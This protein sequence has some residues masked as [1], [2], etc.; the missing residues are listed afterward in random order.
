MVKLYYAPGA[1]SLSPHIVL[2]ETGTPFEMVK[3]DLAAKKAAD[4]SDFYAKNPGGYVPAL[5]TDDGT[6][7][8]EGPVIVTY[9]ADKSGKLAP[10]YGSPERYRM[11]SWLNFITSELHKGFSPLF[12]PRVQDESKAI[13]KDRLKMRLG[14]VDKHLASNDYLLGKSFT[15]PDA[16]LFTVLNWTK[17]PTVAIDLAKEFPN[18]AKFVDRVAERPS[19]KDALKAE[20]AA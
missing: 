16:Y 6:V 18:L 17:R 7:I 13:L 12:N 14:V 3:I 15:V 1:C 10:A 9:L 5:E 19:V 11:M 8:T 4:G 20:A 2:R